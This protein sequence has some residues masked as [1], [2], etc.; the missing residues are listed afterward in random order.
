V[1]IVLPQGTIPR[2][3]DFFDPVLH[4]KTGTARLAAATGATVVPVGL[5]GT[6]KVWPRSARLPDF[7]LVRKPPKVTVR[8]GAPLSLSLTDAK[9]DTAMIMKAISALLPAESRVRHEPTPE[10]LARTKPPR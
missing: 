2:G 3:Y 6:E 4:G 8:V 7:T 1:V 10:E 5:W 9:A